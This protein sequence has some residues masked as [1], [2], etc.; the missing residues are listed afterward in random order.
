M[1]RLP[2]GGENAQFDEQELVNHLRKGL[3][4]YII[5]GQQNCSFDN[6]TKRQSL[7]YWLRSKFAKNPD[8]KQAVNEVVDDLVATGLFE[9]DNKLQCPDSGN[10]CKGLR[11]TPKKE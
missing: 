9:M 2:Y 7:D 4:D 6:H 10:L 8:T 11:L 1:I 5:Q 3:R